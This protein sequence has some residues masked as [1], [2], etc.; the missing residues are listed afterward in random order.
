MPRHAAGHHDIG[1]E[2]VEG[3]LPVEE[4][5]RG[6]AAVGL[7]RGIAE[8][9]EAPDGDPTDPRVVLDDQDGLADAGRQAPGRSRTAP[10]PAAAC[11]PCAGR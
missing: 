7:D 10:A 3:L 9:L 11:S 2:Q 4:P 1:E 8:L 6:G 5:K